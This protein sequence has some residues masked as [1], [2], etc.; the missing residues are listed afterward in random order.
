MAEKACRQ[1]R[2]IYEG[3]KCPRC[4]GDQGLDTF[5]GKIAVLNPEQSELAQKINIK[6]KGVSAIR[7]K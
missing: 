2:A 4:G 6:A 7:L 3:Q 5:K 1:C